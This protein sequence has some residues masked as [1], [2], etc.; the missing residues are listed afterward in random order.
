VLLVTGHWGC[1]ALGES[2]DGNLIGK[3]RLTAGIGDEA[4]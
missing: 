3:K 2:D 4:L 1:M